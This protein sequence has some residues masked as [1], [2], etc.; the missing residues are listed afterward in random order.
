MHWGSDSTGSSKTACV[1]DRQTDSHHNS[2]TH[3]GG[4]ADTLLCETDSSW[5]ARQPGSQCLCPACT[6]MLRPAL[7]RICLFGVWES[8]TVQPV[9]LV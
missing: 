8:V 2:S 6:H 7:P 5:P 9:R 4:Y 3:A 1:T